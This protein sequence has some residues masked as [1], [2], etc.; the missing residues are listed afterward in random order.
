MTQ[1]AIQATSAK[2][3]VLLNVRR[4]LRVRRIHR[5]L[6]IAGRN[7]GGK[8]LA[9]RW[10]VIRLLREAANAREHLEVKIIKHEPRVNHGLVGLAGRAEVDASPAKGH[11][12]PELRDKGTSRVCGEKLRDGNILV[13]NQVVLD[14]ESLL[15]G[16]RGDG[17][18]RSFGEGGSPL[19]QLGAAGRSNG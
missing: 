6:I 1:H 14:L 17:T 4:P 15:N 18:V 3:T 11:G 16:L 5:E 9:E 7:I 12:A 8:Q 13:K 19:G 10:S 2:L